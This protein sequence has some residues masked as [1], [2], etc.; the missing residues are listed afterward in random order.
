MFQYVNG[1]DA[2]E[3]IVWIRQALLAIADAGRDVGIVAMK[4][5]SHAFPQ[6]DRV[7]FLRLEVFET[8]MIPKASTHLQRPRVRSSGSERIPMIE[9]QDA[10]M[11]CRQLFMEV[12]DPVILD[13]NL[14]CR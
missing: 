6:L 8:K 5:I 13:A 10:R 1:Y 7:V 14:F 9:A 3:I 11:V 12:A 2:I 4:H